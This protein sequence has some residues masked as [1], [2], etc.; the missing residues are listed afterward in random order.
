MHTAAAAV[1]SYSTPQNVPQHALNY[2]RSI[3]RG[4]RFPSGRIL[5]RELIR[6][7][8]QVRG[9]RLDAVEVE[10][11][12]LLGRALWHEGVPSPLGGRVFP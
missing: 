5:V 2:G 7:C 9:R 11:A 8:A 10:R 6:V 12:V 3:V 4:L 1:A